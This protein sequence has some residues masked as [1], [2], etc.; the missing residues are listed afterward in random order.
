MAA[1]LNF[2]PRCELIAGDPVWGDDRA[3]ADA[4]RG[5]LGGRW[6]DASKVAAN[7]G[8]PLSQVMAEVAFD[9][10]IEVLGLFAPEPQLRL[11]DREVE[12]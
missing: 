10:D 7:A 11:R 5:A 2:R 4:V 3:G 6:R 8:L 9:D 12:K 1:K